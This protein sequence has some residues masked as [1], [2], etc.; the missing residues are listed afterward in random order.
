MNDELCLL[1]TN[2]LVYAY[3]ISEGKKHRVCKRLVDACWSLK[4]EFAIS[5]QNLSEFYVIV[6]EKIENPLSA[7]IAGGIVQDIIE[8][9]GWEKI[10]FDAHTISSAIKISAKHSIHYWD[11]LLA[12]T[13]REYQVQHIYT[14]D[15]GFRKI[16]WLTVINPMKQ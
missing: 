15:D 12:A 16:P 1:D 2:L 7:E 14:E 13:M 6:T 11:A 10:D 3:D 5:L 4:K 9:Q 8:F